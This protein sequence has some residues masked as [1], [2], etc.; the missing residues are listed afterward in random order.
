MKTWYSMYTKH[1]SLPSE[2]SNHRSFFDNLE[3][4]AQPNYVPSDEDI[5]RS[6]S[7]KAGVTRC[8]LEHESTKFHVYDFGGARC[9][10][11]TWEPSFGRTNIVVFVASIDA[12][13]RCLVEDIGSVSA[14][15]DYGSALRT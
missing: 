13:D 12:Y 6:R 9:L 2:Q 14:G 10:R 4:I 3:R 8:V 15:C 1:V 5:L 7:R 11:K